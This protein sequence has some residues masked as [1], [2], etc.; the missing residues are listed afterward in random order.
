M[1]TTPSFEAIFGQILI[2]ISAILQCIVNIDKYFSPSHCTGLHTLTVY[3]V[4]EIEK[5]I[6]FQG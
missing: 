3:E 2:G 5:G 4:K 1:I 6:F